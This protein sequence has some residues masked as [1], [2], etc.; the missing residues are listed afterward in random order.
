[1]IQICCGN[2][3]VR[4]LHSKSQQTA[5]QLSTNCQPYKAYIL[6]VFQSRVCQSDQNHEDFKGYSSSLWTCWKRLMSTSHS[7]LKKI[8]SYHFSVAFSIMLKHVFFLFLFSM[9]INDGRFCHGPAIQKESSCGNFFI[10]WH[11]LHASLPPLLPL[12][13]MSV[14]GSQW[15]ITSL[16]LHQ[17]LLLVD[18]AIYINVD[19]ICGASVNFG[20]NY[21]HIPAKATCR[22]LKIIS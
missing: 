5:L 12:L 2:I 14:V 10:Q 19:R 16:S 9:W 1:M 7:L 15:R 22:Q 6:Y 20:A 17:W 4:K 3:T 8:S 18:L 13:V 21:T 11:H